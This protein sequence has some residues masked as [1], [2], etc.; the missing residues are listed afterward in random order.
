MQRH[1]RF[2]DTHGVVFQNYVVVIGSCGNGVGR[3]NLD[4]SASRGVHERRRRQEGK[5]S[6]SHVHGQRC[7]HLEVWFAWR[8]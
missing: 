3:V 2:E 5:Q 7:Y 4:L 6:L 1:G 8:L